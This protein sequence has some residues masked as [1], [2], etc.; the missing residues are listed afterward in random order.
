MARLDAAL[1]YPL[2]DPHGDPIPSRE[3][4]L[5]AP[6]DH[7]LTALAANE[8]GIVGRVSAVDPARLRYPADLGP[9]PG[10]GAVRAALPLD[11]PLCPRVGAANDGGGQWVGRE[12]T[13][14]IPVRPVGTVRCTRHGRAAASETSG[15]S[16]RAN[17]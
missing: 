14:D 4:V 3:G 9:A 11:G 5:P 7:P 13:D 10:G 2:G 17:E 6:A 8:G 12:V 15:A 16:E 1:G